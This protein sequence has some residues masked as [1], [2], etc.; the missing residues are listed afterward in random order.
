MRKLVVFNQ[1]SL[2]GFFV[3]MNG[4]MS[5]AHN[6]TK[7]EE[8]DAFVAGNAR[9]GGLLVFG[10]ITYE[11]M[12]SYWPT[13]LA[14]QNDPIVAERMNS[15]PKVVF[16]RTLDKAS[17][18]NTKLVKDGMAAEIRKMKNEPGN[19]MAIMGSGSIVSQLTQER[20]IDEYQIVVIPVVL[21]K[22]RTM[23]DGI[24]EKLSLKLTKTRTFGNG[25]VLLC[26]E[27]M[28]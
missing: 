22:G 24:K 4:E 23:F 20:L 12:K 18:N 17:W 8:W 9:A 6:V 21:G 16:S 14:I 15:L 25:N 28:A 26:Y 11:L 2:D 1:V 5:W 19:D 27:P 13:S 7:D 10:R 3:D